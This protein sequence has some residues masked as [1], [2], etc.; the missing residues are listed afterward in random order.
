[1]TTGRIVPSCQ[2]QDRVMTE[3]K[4]PPDHKTALESLAESTKRLR[5]YNDRL[6]ANLSESQ[7]RILAEKRAKQVAK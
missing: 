2:L 6:E 4:H 5:A 7:R 3:I 1:M